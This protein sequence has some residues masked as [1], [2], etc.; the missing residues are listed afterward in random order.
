MKRTLLLV[1]SFIWLSSATAQTCSI[2]VASTKVCVGSTVLFTVNITGGT[3]LSY[4]WNFGDGF[5]STSAAPN[6]TYLT[7]GT[8][9]PTVTINL[10]GG[11][12]CNATGA[13]MRVF[14]LPVAK[15]TITSDD[16]L[17][18]KGNELCVRDESTAGTS[19]APLNKR[20]FQ[21]SNGFVQVQ[22]APFSN[23]ICYKNTTDILGHL[24]TLVL[25]VT[26]TNGC[27]SRQQKTDSV[28]LLPR[29]P[30]L[31]FTYTVGPGCSTRTANFSNTSL[32][33]RARVKRFYWVFGDGG[34]DSI[35]WN[36]TTY[37]YAKKGTFT[38]FL[39]V[40]D[41]DGCR[42]TA[43]TTSAVRVDVPSLLINADTTQACYA[44]RKAGGGF[45]LKEFNFSSSNLGA[46]VLWEIKSLKTGKLERTATTT[47]IHSLI[48]A[49]SVCGQFEVKTTI[50]YPTCTFVVDTIITVFGPV[51]EIET[52][53]LRII[54][55]RQCVITDTV[56]YLEPTP[57]QICKYNNSR[58]YY[59]WNF[60]DPFAPPCTTDTKN[61]IN[62]GLNCNF[63]VDSINVKHRYKDG[64]E[65]CYQTSL[66]IVDSVLG[67][68][69][70]DTINLPLMSPQADKDTATGNGLYINGLKCLNS[71]LV[72]KL[73]KLVPLPPCSYQKAWINFDSACNKN[74]WVLVDT[75]DKRTY[76]H[77]YFNTCDSSG[78]ITVGVVLQNGNCFDTA[79]YH[80]FMNLKPITA[81]FD[82]TI[83]GVCRPQQLSLIPKDTIQNRLQRVKWELYYRDELLFGAFIFVDSFSQVFAPSDSIILKPKFTLAKSGVYQAIV[84][85][86]DTNKCSAVDIKYI[87]TGHYSAFGAE[88]VH[89][90]VGDTELLFDNVKY[91]DPG[92][93]DFLNPRAY[94]NEP[95]R[96]AANKETITWDIDDGKGFFYKGNGLT[97]KY[98]NPGR[99][100]VKM[101]TQ[102]SLGCKDTVVK[103]PFF[104]VNKPIANIA[105]LQ[106]VYYCAPQ[107]VVFKDSS[108]VIDSINSTRRAIFDSI[109][110][111]VWEFDDNKPGSILKDPSH[112]YTSNGKF[113]TTLTV[114]TLLGCTDTASTVVDIKGPTPKFEI[115]DSLGCSPFEVVLKNTTGTQLKGWTWYFGDA[116]SQILSTDKDTNVHFKYIQPGI[117]NVKLLGIDNIFNPNT[118]NTITCNSFF[119]D[120]VTLLPVRQVVVLPTPDMRIVAKDTICP[121]TPETFKAQ[122][123]S[124]YNIF[125]WNFGDGNT[126]SHS[127]PD[128]STVYQ[129]TDTGVFKIQLIPSVSAG[130]E[131]IDTAYTTI[132]VQSPVA[133][134]EIDATQAPLYSFVNQSLGATRYEWNFGKPSAGANN[135][136]NTLNASFNYG[137]DTGV[138][139][140]CLMAFN[141]N[142]CWDSICKPTNPQARINIPNVFSPGNND[143]KNDA[144]DI[145]IMG[146]T[147]FELQ[148][149][150]RW[151]REVFYSLK[152]GYGNDGINWNGKDKNE[153]ED[154]AAGVYYFILKYK[155]VT[156]QS[157]KTVHG[158]V[159]LVR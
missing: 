8:F 115:L 31:A 26:D 147:S 10:V 37:T 75:S 91:W 1:L 65:G 40:E 130:Y 153:G 7:T 16:T 11:G 104:V 42:D 125:N 64:K 158:T 127:L 93:L 50:T 136:A 30:V 113:T 96:A 79:W 51:S 27:V 82:Y 139:I 99:Y 23:T 90:C 141:E 81:F 4:N 20:I 72:F 55:K 92:T 43:T 106:D 69:H 145:D 33:T 151:G 159:T 157:S 89:L 122:F 60:F 35:N 146:Y 105:T 29:M 97:V 138:S 140:I 49:F 18:F 152:D 58:L 143:G 95:N 117:Y 53:T 15:F 59:Y 110:T 116:S 3:A 88:Q 103:Q 137:G 9:T 123:D 46:T 87:T 63:S 156:E 47:G 5:T 134:F 150:N 111:Y 121:N 62:V 76:G 83:Q 154:C 128:S 129:Y 68:E 149:F 142:D 107:I 98:D 38:P 21:L 41:V 135:T 25:E 112:N 17:C 85:Y 45:T 19:N 118:G 133:D 126:A 101:L 114:T 124:I 24:Y 120:Q 119:P 6:Y 22:N 36:P 66:Y 78:W 57:S 73:D 48:H 80:Q 148:I 109:I 34:I 94:W 61:N 2:Q 108:I 52:D 74:N 77:T 102:D 131:C 56:Y 144:F 44:K 14:T 84:T 67:C 32:I 54:N 12:T 28:R 155:L 100:T 132:V 71:P 13:P 39:V 70:G 86:I